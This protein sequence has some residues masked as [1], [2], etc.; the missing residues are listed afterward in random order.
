MRKRTFT[1]LILS[2]SLAVASLL[3][4]SAHAS[5]ETPASVQAG[6]NIMTLNVDGR[7]QVFNIDP[8]IQGKVSKKHLQQI[9]QQAGP[10]GAINIT[11]IVTPSSGENNKTTPQAWWDVSI[12]WD[13][14]KS[15][16]SRDNATPAQFII[17]VA[18]GQKIKLTE[19]VTKKIGSTIS[20]E[21]AIP[22]AGL[23]KVTGSITG[24]ISKTYTKET[25]FTGP[26]DSSNFVSRAYYWTG[27]QDY[28]TFTLTGKGWP[29]GDTYG[30]YSGSYKEP[31]YYYEW[32]RDIT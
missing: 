25:E 15:V 29:S 10:G 1:K 6:S 4:L 32:S 26:P 5:V 22:S 23:S 27:F 14:V 28:G 31:T 24:E 30:P 3:P 20:G 12:S 18:K 13:V 9:A 17:S 8:S 19:S 11:N 21:G 16:S 2:S 7:S